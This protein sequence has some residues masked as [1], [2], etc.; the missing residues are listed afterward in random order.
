MH[1]EL[2]SQSSQC[3]L[4]QLRVRLRR[5]MCGRSQTLRLA[6]ENLW[7]YAPVYLRSLGAAPKM[8][9]M[10][11]GRS[12][13]FRTSGGEAAYKTGSAAAGGMSTPP[14]TLTPRAPSLHYDGATIHLRSSENERRIDVLA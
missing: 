14:F 12:Q 8:S 1:C 3:G 10:L 9:G 5:P 6:A 11:F 2:S 7:G 4:P 13:T